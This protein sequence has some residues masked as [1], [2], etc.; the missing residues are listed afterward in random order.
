MVKMIEKETGKSMHRIIKDI[1]GGF[2]AFYWHN[3]SKL[4]SYDLKEGYNRGQYNILDAVLDDF[5]VSHRIE[6]QSSLKYITID[7]MRK[8]KR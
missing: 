5:D 7:K 2:K 6:N 3:F 4:Y 1:K 8:R